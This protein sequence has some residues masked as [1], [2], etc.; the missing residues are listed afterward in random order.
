[1]IYHLP[2]LIRSVYQNYPLYYT[3]SI[4]TVSYCESF[5]CNP[6]LTRILGIPNYD[7]LHQ[8]KLELKTNALSVQSN[9]GSAT[10]GDL[11]LLMMNTKQATLSKVSYVHPMHPVIIITPNNAKRVASYELERVYNDNIQIFRKVRGVEQAFIQQVITSVDTQYTIAMKYLTTGQFIEKIRRIYAYILTT[12]GFIFTESSENFEKQV[13]EMQ[14][15]PVTP[16]DNIF[17]KAE[18]FFEY[19]DMENCPYYHPQAIS[20]A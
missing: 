10:H 20:K 19:G 1:M 5:F 16:V 15:D 2:S 3:T 9:L 4:S 6:D 8:M 18:D 17:N 14:Y 12:Y 13:I 7:S 11:R